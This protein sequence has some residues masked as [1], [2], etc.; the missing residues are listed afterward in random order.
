MMIRKEQ[1]DTFSK[2]QVDAFVAR[3][4]KHLRGD[5]P[6]QCEAQQLQEEDLDS[7][8]RQGM[9]DAKQYGVVYEDDIRLYIEC[10]VLLSPK[11]DRDKKNYPWAGEILRRDDIDGTAKMNEIDQHMLF[12]MEEPR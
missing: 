12:G 5:F 4:V 6:A 10:R 7:F 8:V 9:T 3:M 2:S 1:M 11:F